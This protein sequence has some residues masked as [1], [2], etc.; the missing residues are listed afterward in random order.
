MAEFVVIIGNFLIIL[1]LR[2]SR[3]SVFCMHC[4]STCLV[5]EKIKGTRGKS[6]FTIDPGKF[7]GNIELRRE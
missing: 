6:R 7:C 4:L 3:H 2:S 1:L 5:A